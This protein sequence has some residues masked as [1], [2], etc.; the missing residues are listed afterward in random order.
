MKRELTKDK[1]VTGG[2]R[3]KFEGKTLKAF[4]NGAATSKINLVQG[5]LVNIYDESLK[6]LGFLFSNF[7]NS[8]HQEVKRLIQSLEWINYKICRSTPMAG[9]PGFNPRSS[10]TK[11]SKMVFDAGLLNTLHYKIQIKGKWNNLV[12]GVAPFCTLRCSS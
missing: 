6:N 4:Q 1:N 3:E 7:F 11:D 2:K 8:F 12:K 10:H 9:R 5:K